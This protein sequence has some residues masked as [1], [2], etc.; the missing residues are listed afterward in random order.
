MSQFDILFLVRDVH[1]AFIAVVKHI[2]ETQRIA[3]VEPPAYPYIRADLVD[4]LAVRICSR[5]RIQV[6]YRR[7]KRVLQFAVR[8]QLKRFGPECIIRVDA[9]S[10]TQ[11]RGT[12]LQRIH[13]VRAAIDIQPLAKREFD[14]PEFDLSLHREHDTMP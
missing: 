8:I 1:I 10:E 14:L 6:L 11:I 13:R 9:M 3:F 12:F 4:I 2:A 7:I 5:Y